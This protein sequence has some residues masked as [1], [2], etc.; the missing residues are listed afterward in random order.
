M[1]GAVLALLAALSSVTF[2][3]RWRRCGGGETLALAMLA[4]GA[5]LAMLSP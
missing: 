4:A 3:A 5:M 1:S 2:F